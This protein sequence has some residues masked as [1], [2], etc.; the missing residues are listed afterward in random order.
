M[1]ILDILNHDT[2]L[3]IL[4]YLPD[5]DKIILCSSN[6]HL[7][8]YLCNIKL[9]GLY[10]YNKIKD[11]PYYSRFKNIKYETLNKNKPNSVTHLR[12]KKSF[13]IKKNISVQKLL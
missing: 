11:L 4:D 5:K 8:E 1:S 2:I 9:N 10:N 12:L 6:K 3:C 7:R 13:Y